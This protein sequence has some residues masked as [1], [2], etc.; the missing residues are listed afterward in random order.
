MKP[1]YILG[2]LV[3]VFFNAMTST[4]QSLTVMTYNIRLN[5]SSDGV[6]AWPNRKQRVADLIIKADPD[7]F[8]VQE[9]LHDQM[10]DLLEI[11]VHGHRAAGSLGFGFRHRCPSFPFAERVSRTERSE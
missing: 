8:G 5:T 1:Q 2:I 11:V 4:A 3:I 6:N 7:A 9:A 10:Q